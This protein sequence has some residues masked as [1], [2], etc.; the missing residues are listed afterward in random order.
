MGV[1]YTHGCK[2]HSW[3]SQTP[4]PDLLSVTAILSWH[5][6]GFSHLQKLLVSWQWH[7]HWHTI[8]SNTG[9]PMGVSYT[10]GC[11][12]HPWVYPWFESCSFTGD[13]CRQRPVSRAHCT[14]RLTGGPGYLYLLP[15]CRFTVTASSFGTM[16]AVFHFRFAMPRYVS[17]RVRKNRRME[18]IVPDFDRNGPDV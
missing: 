9:T 18:K 8:K 13:G 1:P 2:V 10:H 16:I 3:V 17:Q 4:T 15:R 5:K 11:K 6:I 7:C 12:L 14:P